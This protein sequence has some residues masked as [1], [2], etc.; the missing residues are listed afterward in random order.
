MNHNYQRGRHY[1]NEVE[2]TGITL[3]VQKRILDFNQLTVFSRVIIHVIW[4]TFRRLK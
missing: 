3:A 2:I 1:G 4:L